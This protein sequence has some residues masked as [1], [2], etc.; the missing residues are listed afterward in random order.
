MRIIRPFCEAVPAQPRIL[1]GGCGLGEWTVFLGQQGFDVVGLDLSAEVVDRLKVRFP[2]TQ[3]VRGDIRHTGFEAESFD[4]CFSWGA[5]EHFENGIGDCL[6]EAH[7]VLRPGGWL[8]ISVPFDN[9]R[10]IV[11]GCAP[12]RRAGMRASIPERLS[13]APAVLPMAFYPPRIAT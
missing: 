10:H 4:A 13:A 7:R 11:R 2:A 6:D 5:F 3:F 12:A 9:W 1:D 8:F